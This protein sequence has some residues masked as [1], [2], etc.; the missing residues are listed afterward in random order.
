MDQLP[1]TSNHVS[2]LQ[3]VPQF[4]QSLHGMVMKRVQLDAEADWLGSAQIKHLSV[5]TG[6]G[7]WKKC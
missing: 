6:S 3:F 5:V 7:H 1:W 2:T 4:N